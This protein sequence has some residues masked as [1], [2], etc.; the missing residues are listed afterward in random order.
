M[1]VHLWQRIWRILLDLYHYTANPK[2]MWIE[3][4]ISRTKTANSNLRNFKWL[5]LKSHLRW[6]FRAFFDFSTRPIDEFQFF[7]TMWQ[8][9]MRSNCYLRNFNWLCLKSHLRRFFCVFCD[10]FP[11]F[12]TTN[13]LIL[14]YMFFNWSYRAC[15]KMQLSSW[16]RL[17]KRQ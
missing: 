11:P 4:T 10:S 1:I 3:A 16:T 12:S 8:Q 2:P 6:F 5:Y 14:K 7:F 15:A 9:S 17:R 13:S